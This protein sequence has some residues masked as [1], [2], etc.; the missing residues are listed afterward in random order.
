MIEFIPYI[1]QILLSL[2][3][4]L[5]TIFLHKES[6]KSG[7][8]LISIAFF[9]S[10]VPTIL[11]LALGAPYLALQL[12]EQG[13]TAAEIGVFHFYLFLVSSAFQIVFAIFVI[14]GL[15]KLSR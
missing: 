12:M 7:L 1:F 2:V 15:V 6:E 10:A 11:S 13:Y 3:I 5:V 4:G 9:I 14:A 8:L